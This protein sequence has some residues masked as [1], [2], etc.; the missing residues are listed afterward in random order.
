[1]KAKLQVWDIIIVSNLSWMVYTSK[2]LQR[3]ETRVCDN[4]K[5]RKEERVIE[6]VEEKKN[7]DDYFLA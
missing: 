1:M 5:I 7:Y 2:P 4:C 6:V 3:D